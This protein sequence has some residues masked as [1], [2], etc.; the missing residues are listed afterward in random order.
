MNQMSKK[1]QA[2]MLTYISLVVFCLMVVGI[3]VYSYVSRYHCEQLD[4][5][6]RYTFS[7]YV[8]NEWNVLKEGETAAF[9]GENTAS[10]ANPDMK[11]LAQLWLD[12]YIAQYRQRYVPYS[13]QIK[14]FGVDSVRI[15][16]MDSNTVLLSFWIMPKDTESDYLSSWDGI[17]DNGKLKCEWVVSFYLNNNYDNTASLYVTSVMSSEDYG[18]KQYY[19]KQNV[20]SGGDTEVTSNSNKD[21]LANYTIRDNSLLVT[22]DGERYVPVPVSYSYLL[23]EENSS[24]V[25]KPGSYMITTEKTAFVYGGKTANNTKIPVT[26]VYS[27]D[28]GENWTTCELDNIYNADYYYVKFFDANNGVVVC[29]YGK[30]NDTN[31]SSRIYKTSNGGESWDIVG[32]GP[33]TNIIKGVVFVTADI[34]FFCYDYVE[35]MDSNLYKTEDGGKTFAKVLLEAQELDS[36]AANSQNQENATRGEQ[37]G[38]D[39]AD[40][41]EQLKWNDVYKEAITPVVDSNGV[42]TIYLTQG[43]TA[44]YNDGKTAAKY[45]SSD[46]G[47]TWKYIGQVEIKE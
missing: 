38:K 41:S 45:Q 34:G 36:S 46:N 15:L 28:K 12:E 14:K 27:D 39:N 33:A 21:Q 19:A 42:I 22:Y 40:T 26:V 31:E 6:S 10:F 18:L 35:G 5:K 20:D 29:G 44:V 23:Y 13:K 43:K 16:D 37:G 32:S 4:L 9:D 47:T 3:F 30:S 24:T 1:F 7:I 17:L 25:L 11:M 8:D 2:K